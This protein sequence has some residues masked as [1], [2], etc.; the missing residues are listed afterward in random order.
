ME[1]SK[2]L[3]NTCISIIHIQLHVYISKYMQKQNHTL[4]TNFNERTN[5]LLY[6]NIS[7]T[8]NSWKGDVCCVRDWLETRTDS[9]DPKFFFNHSSTSFSSWLGLLNRGSLRAQSPL[10][11]A[12]SHF[13]ILSPTNSNRPGHLVILL[14]DTHLL[15]LFSHYL[16]SS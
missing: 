12:G 1:L 8:L 4:Y 14:S 5:T 6:K 2:F 10:S 13:G 3:N 11:P 9:Y 15:P 7:L 16:V